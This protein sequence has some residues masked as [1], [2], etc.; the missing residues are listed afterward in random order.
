MHTP[1][2]HTINIS[3][4]AH[5]DWYRCRRM[6][7]NAG[8]TAM[9]LINKVTVMAVCCWFSIR[10]Y[11][12]WACQCLFLLAHIQMCD[13]LC[14]STSDIARA[15]VS[16]SSRSRAPF[17]VVRVLWALGAFCAVAVGRVT[18]VLRVAFVYQTTPKNPFSR[19]ECTVKVRF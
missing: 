3:A 5:V 19:R 18:H 9:N 14:C 1:R 16:A 6:H 4:A 17:V 8:C 11:A 15:T 7:W 12:R 13:Y 10:R 2:C